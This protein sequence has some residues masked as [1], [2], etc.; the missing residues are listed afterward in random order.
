MG[1]IRTSELWVGVATLIGSGLVAFGIV[2]QEAWD[3][4]FW[5]AV[6]YIVSRLTS[7]A[8]KKIET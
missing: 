8:A 3:K 4:I 7:K 2:D 5:P 1:A 6:V